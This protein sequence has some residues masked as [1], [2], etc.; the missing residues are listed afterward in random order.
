MD[1]KHVIIALLH[2]CTNDD[3]KGYKKWLVQASPKSLQD[4]K[5]CQKSH[6]K[7]PSVSLW[8]A[9]A[10]DA[11]R[12]RVEGRGHYATHRIEPRVV[13][14]HANWAATGWAATLKSEGVGEAYC[15]EILEAI[16]RK[17]LRA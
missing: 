17:I 16:G 4:D 1:R 5:L 2:Q 3:V 12:G 13:W 14:L 11:A 6:K 8:R 7:L 10:A 9:V 15:D